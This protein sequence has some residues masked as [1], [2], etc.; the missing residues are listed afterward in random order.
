MQAKRARKSDL[1]RNAL[2][3][4]GL[5]FRRAVSGYSLGMNDIPTSTANEH[6]SPTSTVRAVRWLPGIVL[7][8]LHWIVQFAMRLFGDSNFAIF[9]TTFA[10]PLVTWLLFIIAWLFFSRRTWGE[11]LS[12]LATFIA[13]GVLAGWAAHSTMK[14]GLIL[15]CLPV[16]LTAWAIWAWVTRNDVSLSRRRVTLAGTML[17]VASYFCL[18]RLDGVDGDMKSQLSWRWSPTAEEKFLASV[19]GG[20]S[21][22]TALGDASQSS[23]SAGESTATATPIVLQPGDWPGFRGPN[24]DSVVTGVR[25][26]T[27][28]V[29]HPPQ[30]VWQHA[31]GPGWS[32]FAAVSGRLFTQEQRGDDECVTCY[33]AATG[34]EHW[35]HRHASRFSEPVAGAGPRATPQFHDSKLFVQGASGHL[36]C[37]DAASGREIWKADVTADSKATVPI[38]GFSGS[39]LIVDGIVVVIPGDKQGETNG[40]SVLG[41]QVDDGSLAWKAGE[42]VSGY[43][44]AHLGEL[45]GQAQV[46]SLTSAGA[47]S[48]DP[49]TGKPMWQHDWVSE[50]E[51][52]IAQPMFVT[53]SRLLI[54]TGQSL[55]ARLLDVT[56]SGDQWQ[57]SEVWT[58]KEFRPYFNDYVQHAGHAFGLDN[59]LLCCIDLNTGKRRWK[60][61]RYGHGQVLLLADQSLLLVLAESGEVALLEA[62]PDSHKELAKAPAIEGKTWNHPVLVGTNLFLRNAEQAACLRFK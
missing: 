57:T 44:S 3:S 28:W 10:G 34:V 46:I 53:N 11:R 55:G 20:P 56:H 6:T 30:I 58:S 49:A 31:I 9:M 43:T 33:D 27:N 59:G 7:V 8:G 61:G 24:R 29:A 39:P 41:Y 25:I 35:C 50:Q 21:S 54:P 40:S 18:L 12:G 47:M 22:K 15:Y 32:S 60:K 17:L 2:I 37:L 36:F 4:H 48:L 38:W 23:D 45:H 42:G 52:R 26:E 5:I 51:L 62:N 13:V 14:F 19:R 1:S 16:V